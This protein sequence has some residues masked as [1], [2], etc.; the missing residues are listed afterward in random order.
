VNRLVATWK[1]EN[2]PERDLG[3]ATVITGGGKGKTVDVSAVANAD[4]GLELERKLA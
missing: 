2:R 3:S 4:I 1:A